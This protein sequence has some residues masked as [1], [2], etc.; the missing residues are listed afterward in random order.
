MAR[1]MPKI[2]KLLRYLRKTKKKLSLA[3]STKLSLATSTKHL[4]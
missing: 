3:T 4:A 2:I 1:T